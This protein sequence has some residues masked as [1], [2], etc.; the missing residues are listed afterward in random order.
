[1]LNEQEFPPD[2]IELQLAHAETEQGARGVQQGAALRRA[3]ENDAVVGRLSRRVAREYNASG[4]DSRELNSERLD[5]I[6]DE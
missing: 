5:T 2:V 4:E 3:K 1:L 6:R